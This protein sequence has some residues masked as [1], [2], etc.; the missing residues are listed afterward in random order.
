MHQTPMSNSISFD[1]LF[2]QHQTF[3]TQLNL[4]EISPIAEEALRNENRRKAIGKEMSALEK[5]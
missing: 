4:I 3:T 1:R 2:S 5:N